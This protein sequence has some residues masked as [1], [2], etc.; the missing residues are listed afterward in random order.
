[1]TSSPT[2]YTVKNTGNI[3]LRTVAVNDPTI[4]SVSCPVPPAPGLTPGASLTC[5]ANGS[6]LVTQADVDTG[7][8]TDTATATRT[9]NEVVGLACSRGGQA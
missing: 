2:G 9:D 8:V 3:N 5:T 1:M 4:G 6:H 7:Q